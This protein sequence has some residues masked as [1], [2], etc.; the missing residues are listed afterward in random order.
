L[1]LTG[2]SVSLLTNLAPSAI[3]CKEP[4]NPTLPGP[5]RRCIEAKSFRSPTVKKA[6]A[7]SKGIKLFNI[8]KI[9]DKK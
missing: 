7:T 2:I 8:K 5:V 1:A 3:A 9:K 4:Q 6:I